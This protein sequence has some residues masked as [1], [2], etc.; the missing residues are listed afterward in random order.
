MSSFFSITKFLYYKQ[1]FLKYMNVM[2]HKK[3]I[4]LEY[5]SIIIS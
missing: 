3:G 4:I 2:H 5:Y 1:T